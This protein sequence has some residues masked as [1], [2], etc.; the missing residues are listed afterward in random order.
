MMA[1][2]F[3]LV[4][5]AG[6]Y[7]SHGPGVRYATDA[8]PGFSDESELLGPAK[9]EP[10]LFGWFF[11]PEK[12]TAAEQYAWCRECLSNESWRAARNGFDALVR[13][14]PTASEAPLAQK[15][16][17]D[18]YA[19]HYESYE[20]AYNEYRYLLDFYSSS[21][22]YAAV[23]EAAYAM[24]TNMLRVGKT[25]VFFPFANTVDVRRA[26][27]GVVLRSPG[28]PF[29]P[30]AM[31]TI[32]SLREDEDKGELAVEVY[33]NLRSLHP[34]SPEAKKALVREANVRMKL[35]R[36]HGYNRERCQ[37]TIDF[38]RHALAANRDFEGRDEV[39]AWLAEAE[40]LIEDEAFAAA[41]YYDSPTRSRRDAVRAYEAFM[42]NYPA[43][44]HV[45]EA[46][47]RLR[48]LKGEE[49]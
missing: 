35:L 37:A 6:D 39:V 30:E 45:A 48:E 20:E 13:E 49:K 26:I 18:L 2:A 5:G 43:S 42:R 4:A 16:L 8:Y 11:G 17:A 41:R 22:D 1:A 21:C 3:A 10:R 29:V 44:E 47:A 25:V 28:A 9:K 24:A 15:A 12:G 27:E 34:S 32:A 46:Q 40:R 38:L 19:T 14:W 33:E 31:L 36:E 7:D 23:V